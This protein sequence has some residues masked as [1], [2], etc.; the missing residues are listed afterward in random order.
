MVSLESGLSVYEHQLA[1][2]DANPVLM[3]HELGFW[4]G[5]LEVLITSHFSIIP[6]YGHDT[7]QHSINKM[8][9]FPVFEP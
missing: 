9:K 1:K 5:Y 8:E 3:V 7:I 4:K 6:L 2:P